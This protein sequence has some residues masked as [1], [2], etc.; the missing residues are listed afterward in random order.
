MRF[1]LLLAIVPCVLLLA[2]CNSPAVK[3]ATDSNTLSTT[4]TVTVPQQNRM[5]AQDN[6]QLALDLIEQGDYPLA[7]AK[8]VEAQ[9]LDPHLAAVYYTRGYFNEKVRDR[10]A[11]QQWYRQAVKIAP[12]NPQALNA[13][14]VFLCQT[15]E[16]QQ[17]LTYF[18]R[19][20]AVPSYT[21]TGLSYQNAGLCALKAKET[22]QAIHYLQA[23]VNA[24]PALA[25]SY[26]T[27]A[28]LAYQ[29]H[30]YQSAQTYL[31][32]YNQLMKPTA[33]SLQLAIALAKQ[34]G[35][36]DKAAT[37]QLQLESLRK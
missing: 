37:L 35:D 15:G 31:N 30:H 2:G 26:F 25:E 27:L 9:R 5:A 20:I 29:Q 28:K 4:T 12:H 17:S 8:L 1:K 22:A 33:A 34:Q 36:A 21:N 13:Y 6:V 14:G 11:A 24:N 32:H 18:K 7:K 23:A 3:Q 10:A 16:Y 19:A